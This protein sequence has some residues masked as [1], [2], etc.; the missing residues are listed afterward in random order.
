[1]SFALFNLLKRF[2]VLLESLGRSLR[3]GLVQEISI[4]ICSFVSFCHSFQE[5]LLHHDLLLL[6]FSQV[7]SAEVALA[8]D[9]TVNHLCR[10]FLQT[11]FQFTGFLV[12]GRLQLVFTQLFM[13]LDTV[14][15]LSDFLFRG[16]QS[17]N[18]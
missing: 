6:A 17:Y 15:E 3:L 1:M 2:A 5:D 16:L 12:F 18:L 13:L 11:I 14:G 9:V 8:D 7:G 4:K 10:I